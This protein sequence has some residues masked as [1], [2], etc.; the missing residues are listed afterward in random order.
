MKVPIYVVRG[1]I[2][3]LT[4]MRSQEDLKQWNDAMTGFSFQKDEFDG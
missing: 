1:F 3:I 2:L 4:L